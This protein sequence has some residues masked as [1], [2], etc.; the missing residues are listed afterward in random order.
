MRWLWP[1]KNGGRRDVLEVA[2]NLA[3]FSRDK[4]SQEISTL[5]AVSI[6]RRIRKSYVYRT[7]THTVYWIESYLKA[8]EHELIEFISNDH[9]Y[10]TF[11][12]LDKDKT[13]IQIVFRL[14]SS[15]L[16]GWTEYGI[17]ILKD[18]EFY[19]CKE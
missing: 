12:L 6:P 17:E 15:G 8:E 11:M 13:R 1:S 18:G 5:V 7:F 4:I 14:Q 10:T 3:E 16:A 19:A 2:I 9:S